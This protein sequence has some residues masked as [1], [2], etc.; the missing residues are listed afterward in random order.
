MLPDDDD[1]GLPVI[2][3]TINM[4]IVTTLTRTV[5]MTVTSWSLFE[6]A[7]ELQTE[8]RWRHQHQRGQH[9]QGA[10]TSL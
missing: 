10:A 9:G 6:Y 5:V 4:T 7:N 8:Q 3:T 1:A 2:I